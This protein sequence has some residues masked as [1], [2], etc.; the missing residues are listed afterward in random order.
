MF[1][2]PLSCHVVILGRGSRKGIRQVS[3]EQIIN[4]FFT[5]GEVNTVCPKSCPFSIVSY[6]VNW[7]KTSWTH[8]ILFWGLLKNY[9]KASKWGRQGILKNISYSWM[10]RKSIFLSIFLFLH[11]PQ[12]LDNYLL[13]LGNSYHNYSFTY[14]LGSVSFTCWLSH[15][16]YYFV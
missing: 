16:L 15:V 1:H 12:R 5:K 6:Y 9:C 3:Y 2:T 8:N 7:A 10:H 11:L 13:S 14:Y 4:I